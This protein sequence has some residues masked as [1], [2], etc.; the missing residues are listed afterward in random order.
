MLEVT[1]TDTQKITVTVILINWKLIISQVTQADTQDLDP[2]RSTDTV[3]HWIWTWHN[4]TYGKPQ[5]IWHDPTQPD[6]TRVWPD[7]RSN[8]SQ[9]RVLI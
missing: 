7:P 3:T 1:Q 9:L 5:F 8:L 6:Q 2:T 4:P